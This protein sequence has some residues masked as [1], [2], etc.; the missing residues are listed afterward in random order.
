MEALRQQIEALKATVHTLQQ[1]RSNAGSLNTCIPLPKPINVTEGDIAENFKFFQRSWENYLKASGLSKRAND[2]QIAVLMT[3]VGDEVFKRFPNFNIEDEDQQTAEK[4]LKAI[5][6]NL[7]PQV[8]KRY[9]RAV[10]NLAK[11]EENEKYVDYFNRLRT[12]LKNCQYGTLEDDLLLDKIICSIKDTSLRERLW[13][14]RNIT[15]DQAID[16]CKA[17][18]L[19]Q[20]QLRNIEESHDE[21]KK[22]QKRTQDK[23]NSKN[24]REPNSKRQDKECKYCGYTHEPGKCPAKGVT[25]KKC[26]KKDHYARVCYSKGKNTVKEIGSEREENEED[27]L[28]ITTRNPKQINTELDFIINDEIIKV[29]CQLDTGATCNVVGYEEFSKIVGSSSPKVEK[30]STTL[31]CFSGKMVKPVGQATL[32]CLKHHKVYKIKFEIVSWKHR[33]LLSAEACE[34]LRLIKVCNKVEKLENEEAQEIINRY[35]EVFEGMGCI[36]GEVNL[37]VDP[38]VMPKVQQP[39]RVPVAMME[40]LRKNIEEMEQM[41]IIKKE[42]GYTKWVSNILLVRRNGKTRICLDPLHLNQ[43]LRGCDYQM[44]TIEEILPELADARV[45]TTLDAKKGFWQLKLNDESS[46]LTIFWTPFGK[47]KYLRLP[48]GVKPAMQIYQKKQHEIVQGLRGTIAIADD[49][50]VYGKGKTDEEAIRDHNRNLEKLMKRLK[51]ANLKLNKEKTKLCQKKVKFYGHILTKEGSTADPSKTTAIRDMEEPKNKAELLGFLGMLTYISKYI[52]NL[53]QKAE[54][55]RKLTRLDQQFKWTETEQEAFENLK[56]A[57]ITP[58]ILRFYDARKPIIIQTDASSESMGCTLLQEGLPIAY[59]AKA[60]NETQKKYCQL[61]KEA[62][63]IL[64]A[65]QRFDQYICGKDEVVIETDHKPLINIFSKQIHAAPKRIQSI[66]LRLQRYNIRLVYRKG[67]QMHVADFLSRIKIKGDQ[68]TEEE[69]E[70]YSITEDEV[71]SSIEEAKP[72]DGA[73]MRDTT[74]EELKK[75]TREDVVM[76]N[77]Y[78]VIN[79]GLPEHTS[80]VP[81]TLKT[82]W[83][84]RD[85]LTTHQGL[86]LKG[87]RVVVP[88]ELRKEMLK[89]LHRSHQGIENTTKLARGTVFWPNMNTQIKETVQSCEIC[90]KYSRS[91]QNPPMLTHEIP[92]FPFQRVNMDVFELRTFEVDRNNITKRYLVTVDQYSDFFE[93]DELKHANTE[94]TIQLCKR[95]FSRYG[96]PTTVITDNGSNFT[97]EKFKRFTKEWNFQ[98]ITSSPN[99]QQGNGKAEA[100]VKIAKGLIKKSIE[101]RSDVYKMLLHWRNTPNKMNSSPAQRMFSRRLRSDIPMIPSKLKPEVIADVP[102]AIQE[103]RNNSKRYYDR[104]SQNLPSPRKDSNVHFQKNPQSSTTWTPGKIKKQINSRTFEV[105]NEGTTYRRSLVHIKTPDKA[106]SSPEMRNTQDEVKQEEQTRTKAT[107]PEQPLRRSTRQRRIPDKYSDV[108]VKAKGCYT[109][110]SHRTPLD[111]PHMRAAPTDD[112]ASQRPTHDK[113]ADTASASS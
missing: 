112:A 106:A 78:N 95:N 87:S 49:I 32:K 7:T 93:I 74:I 21:V 6:R 54:Q 76:T 34:Q 35:A 72:L 62:T 94:Y 16:K 36:E 25:C 68:K 5:G 11:Q 65:C 59:A 103:Q 26:S 98:H 99:H 31:K 37:E 4:V 79:D 61:E 18:E 41:G 17:K 96:I 113:M 9:E 83:K 40:E 28:N 92:T 110:T 24:F 38:D 55:L 50:L 3:A 64:F 67:T 104:S 109:D 39:R 2:E 111:N 80:K 47:Y 84:Y 8:N 75:A 29:S 101:T 107:D 71:L 89:R 85:E 91:Q 63:A 90:T 81:D 33:P 70:V 1:E 48:F 77:L 108:V 57:I 10:F 22:F 97:S 66:I 13:M 42:D 23:N 60:L 53:S 56:K 30:S 20:Q 43:A 73:R 102:Q 82:Y 105:E 15:L 100:A 44:P 58:P 51:T 19:S 86:I 12:L 52:P 45:F 46:K 14:D 88:L 69:L 27:I